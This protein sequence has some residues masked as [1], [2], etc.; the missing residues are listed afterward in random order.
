MI[1]VL[2]TGEKLVTHCCVRESNLRPV[3]MQ[4]YLPAWPNTR[5]VEH[6]LCLGLVWQQRLSKTIV[7]ICLGN[8]YFNFG[9]YFILEKKVE[10]EVSNKAIKK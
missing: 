10:T 9:E 5:W 1:A 4:N 8:G 7:F 2:K 3:P 6:V